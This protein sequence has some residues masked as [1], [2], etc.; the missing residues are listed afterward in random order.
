PKKWLL[1]LVA[2]AAAGGILLQYRTLFGREAGVSLLVVMLALKLLE[3][4]TRRDGMLLGFLGCFLL[5]TNFLHSQTIPTALY[6]LVCAWLLVA[7]L[8]VMQYTGTWPGWRHP[9]KR[10]GILIAQALPLM[11]VLFLLFPRVQGPL[12][13][14]PQDAY[15]GLSGLS[16]NMSPG[17]LNS[18]I[19]SDSVAFR[20]E[21]SDGKTPDPKDLYWRG[22][23]LWDYD[24]RTWTA[25]RLVQRIEELPAD[26]SIHYTVTLEPHNK[27]WLFALEFPGQHPP[28]SMATRDMQLLSF[29]PVRSRMRYEMTS[30]IGAAYGADDDQSVLSR[31]LRLPAGTNPRTTA[32]AGELRGRHGD[33]RSLV[34]AVLN[35]FRN[36]NFVYTLSPPLLGEQPVDEFLFDTRR[37]FCEHYASAFTVLMRAAGIPARVV[38]GYLGGEINPVGGY[39]LV[40]QADAHAWVEI[41][42]EKTGWVRVDP[43]AAV[44]PARVERGIASALPRSD[45]LPIFV[46]GDFAALQRMRLTWDSIT[47]TWNQ[48][49]LGYTPERQRLFLSH[50]GFSEASWQTM[51]VMLLIFAGIA[52]LF[53]A[54]LALRDLRRTRPDAA[55]AAYDR[56]CRKLARRGLTRAAAEGPRTFARRAARQRPD[57]A[58][59]IDDITALY[60][61]L[62]YAGEVRPG[63]LR[64]LERRSRAFK[65]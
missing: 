49:V 57:L 55:K 23:V 5:V 43:T 24:G 4:G 35:M 10:A 8:I 39:I 1:A 20:A 17:S 58:A 44:S 48:W 7:T 61:G 46:R 56:F 15:A 12:W 47:Y 3:T 45:P 26:G 27:R 13:G 9:V 38:T 18:L 32:F 65:A 41:W 62:R 52:V 51:S 21:F 2:V 11:A 28:R 60:I 36:E 54:A 53:G 33:D 34:A 19:L 59:A 22:P 64:M 16:D 37:G 42:L 50:L 6:M 25:P 63:S 29:T 31:A 40:R 14:L 30:A